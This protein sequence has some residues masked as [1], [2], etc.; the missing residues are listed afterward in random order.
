M[1]KSVGLCEWYN[2]LG[3]SDGVFTHHF[4]LNVS[5]IFPQLSLLPDAPS[6]FSLFYK[7]PPWKL[8]KAL[9]PCNTEKALQPGIVRCPKYPL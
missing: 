8:L 4:V 1:T 9:L 7:L 6:I 5:I 3:G 2:M